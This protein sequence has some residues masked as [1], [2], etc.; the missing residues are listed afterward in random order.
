MEFLTG[1]VTSNQSQTET[2]LTQES[3]NI[4]Q[5]IQNFSN[6]LSSIS[7]A[8]TASN[9]IVIEGHGL[10]NVIEPLRLM[11]SK[12]SSALQAVI[13]GRIQR[14]SSTDVEWFVSEMTSLMQHGY[15]AASRGLSN[16]PQPIS[17]TFTAPLGIVFD[18]KRQI[19]T[20]PLLS[21]AFSK[22]PNGFMVIE[23]TEGFDTY[24]RNIK[25]FRFASFAQGVLGHSGAAGVFTRT[26]VDAQTPPSVT[27][28]IRVLNVVPSTSE[29]F[30]YAR[31]NDVEG[32]Q[33]LFADRK[34]SPF[35][36]NEEG[37]SLLAV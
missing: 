18:I 6:K 1:L 15:Q 23:Y 28:Q 19:R 8:E 14:I 26:H 25:R 3:A 13:E 17:S 29:A 35:D 36:Y 9:D 21:S 37:N 5:G 10:E 4:Q 34:A 33:R 16:N 27:R 32:L 20:I 11:R 22:G 31:V 12:L 30:K 2:L 24:R 7:F